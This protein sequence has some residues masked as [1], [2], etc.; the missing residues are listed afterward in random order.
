MTAERKLP[1]EVYKL[2]RAT[3]RVRTTGRNFAT[4]PYCGR[5]S[6]AGREAMSIGSVCK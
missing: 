1:T 5:D 2:W 3:R 6:N 4:H